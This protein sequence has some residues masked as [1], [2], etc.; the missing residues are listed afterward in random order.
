MTSCL[1]CVPPGREG[2]K[3]HGVA[4]TPSGKLE[5]WQQLKVA[6]FTNAAASAW[7]LALLDMLLR[8]QLNILGRHLFLASHLCSNTC[9]HPSGLLES[10][11]LHLH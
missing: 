10:Y 4:A 2:K 1:T 7:L 8:V 3:G 11:D 6:A 5:T 9:V